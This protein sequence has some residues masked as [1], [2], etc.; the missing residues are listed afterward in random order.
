MATFSEVLNEDLLVRLAGD[1]SFD[2]GFD[3]YEGG[4]VRS[5]AQY[6][7]R[8]T[9]KVDGTQTYQ[10]ELWLRDEK[11]MFDCSCPVGDGGDFCKHCVA[12]ALTWIEEPPPYHPASESPVIEGT[13][14]A[15]LYQYLSRQDA[16]TLVDLIF[17]RAMEDPV[18]HQQL[19]LK[20]ASPQNRGVPD[21]ATLRSVLE[22]AIVIDDFDD[23]FVGYD[24][25]SGYA[26]R[27]E[28]VVDSIK[29]LLEAG[30][31]SDAVE[32]TQEAIDL[33]DKALN[34]ID[35]S[36]G[37]L[38]DIIDDL[39]EL[40]YRACEAARPDPHAL[41]KW[42]L[43][44][45]LDMSFF[46]WEDAIDTYQDI[47]GEEGINTYKQLLAI[48]WDNLP[49]NQNPR[50]SYDWSRSK[51]T[52]LQE[53]F[54]AKTGSLE[55]IVAVISK[56]LSSSGRY[57]K[58]AELY[59]EAGQID[60]AIDWAERGFEEFKE[61]RFPSSELRHFLVA[62]Y[63]WQG[64]IEDAITTVW[65]AFYRSPSFS[66]YQELK[67]QADKINAW[68][69]WRDTALT[70][71]QQT[72]DRNRQSRHFDNSLLVEI[73]MWEEDFDRAWQEEKSGGCSDNL[74]MQLADRS[75]MNFPDDSLAVYKREIEL[76]VGQTNDR[77]Y[78]QAAILI[79]KVKALLEKLD[80]RS[81]Y[82]QFIGKLTAK[83]RR[84]RKFVT[85]LKTKGLD[86]MG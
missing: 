45:A 58:I 35:D 55:E 9:A 18:W 28:S 43:R 74:R 57:L 21:I 14:T 44:S 42:L 36:D 82:K 4:L 65:R 47:L 10:V 68:P 6:G 40:H 3:Y 8:I 13:T 24:E 81:D 46:G 52:R 48:E 17:D 16:K 23:Y 32:L 75:G 76:A 84:K 85:L 77:G 25:A 63:N 15:D 34:S 29:E 19:L 37:D 59:E 51:L 73:F 27:V 49:P 72:N 78:N 11:L 66:L 50:Y 70:H 69:K 30:Y 67:Q 41:A 31:A 1:R 20:A 80:R 33:L 5:L 83:H 64:R 86:S 61:Q 62:T 71:I 7:D 53:K 26:D 12:V 60:T 79:S 2:R 22:D 39:P 54:V 38:C 56:D